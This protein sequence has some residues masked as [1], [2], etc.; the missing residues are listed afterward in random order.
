MLI[1]YVPNDSENTEV[2]V[3][4]SGRM[5]SQIRTNDP[6]DVLQVFVWEQPGV[7]DRTGHGTTR[8]GVIS[9]HTRTAAGLG[10]LPHRPLTL[11]TGAAALGSPGTWGGSG[12]GK[13]VHSSPVALLLALRWPELSASPAGLGGEAGH[14]PPCAR[15]NRPSVMP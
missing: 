1:E 2:L 9:P 12:A 7:L 6:L 11:E 14:S 8:R 10:A 4:R 3:P 13:L 15:E 5:V